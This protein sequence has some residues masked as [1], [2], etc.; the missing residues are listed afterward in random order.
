MVGESQEHQLWLTLN[1]EPFAEY[2]IKQFQD[3]NVT[4]GFPWL[5]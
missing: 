1:N 2:D 5:P 3:V 4:L